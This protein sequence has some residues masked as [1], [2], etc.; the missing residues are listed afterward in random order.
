M[1]LFLEVGYRIQPI[2]RVVLLIKHLSSHLIIIYSSY[3]L[4]VYSLSLVRGFSF[5][6]IVI[7]ICLKSLF[8]ELTDKDLMIR[9][10]EILT[11]IVKGNKNAMGKLYSLGAFE[12][13]LWKF[14]AGDLVDWE[15]D[16]ICKFLLQC[17]LLQVFC[18]YVNLNSLFRKVHNTILIYLE[19]LVSFLVL[20]VMTSNL[21][22]PILWQD[23]GT[24]LNKSVIDPDDDQ[25]LCK[26][27]A[28]RLYIPDAII[29]RVMSEVC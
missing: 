3:F 22:K 12:I 18:P 17:H 26:A 24:M 23:Q 6:I 14:L 10:L 5:S 29:I 15:K 21:L 9:V 2:L 25:S 13:L 27:S 7:F 4:V 28:L 16:T 11:I 20:L 8:S 1:G 19:T